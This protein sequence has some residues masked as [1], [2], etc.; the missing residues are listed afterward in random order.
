MGL[1]DPTIHI[2]PLA[3]RQSKKQKKRFGSDN[4]FETR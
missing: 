2:A 4:P 1:A 3:A